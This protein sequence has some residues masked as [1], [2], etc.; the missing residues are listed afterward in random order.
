[1]KTKNT[2]TILG[3][4][5]ISNISNL[6]PSF[7]QD[8]HFSQFNMTPLILNPA[9]TGVEGDQRA[10]LNYKNQWQ[11][12]GIS[13][14]TYSTSLF[15]FDMRLFKK[16]WRKGYLGAGTNAYKDVAGDLKL[17]TTQLN[18]SIAG[19]VFINET[20]LFSGGLQGGYVQKSLSAAPMQWDSQY[21]ASTGAF[22]SSLPSNDIT[23]VP[24][25]RYGDFSAGIAWNY[26][27]KQSTLSAHDQL[28]INFGL[29]AFNINRPKQNFY[30]NTSSSA[31]G[32]NDKLYSR[33]VVHGNALIGIKNTNG[34]LTPNVV[35]FKQGPSYELNMGML[36][37]WTLKEPSVYTGA[38]KEMAFSF[39]AQYRVRDAIIPMMLFEYSHYA[40]GL[41]Y[42]VTTSSLTQGTHGR[43]GF[44]ISLKY[45]NPNP[46]HHSAP[47]LK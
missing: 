45:V 19:I 33:F 43:G 36:F 11:G 28:K 8:V 27:T 14:A 10:Y 21:D 34:A 38:F 22:N 24:V 35:L 37:R 15:S 20:Q 16:K 9:L 29:A 32:N 31:V 23:S 25:V 12:M 3:V 46:F 6:T 17:G 18:L 39:G 4:I 30:K 7:A 2:I 13:G 42:D 41:S 47:R 26:D 44:E 40:L 5:L 1:M